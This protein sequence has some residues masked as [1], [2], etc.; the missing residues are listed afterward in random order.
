MPLVLSQPPAKNSLLGTQPGALVLRVRGPQQGGRLLRLRSTKCTIGASPDCTLRLRSRG[1]RPVHCL[2]LRGTAGTFVRRWSAGTYLN[3]AAFTESPLQPGDRLHIGPVE[4]EV[5]QTGAETEPCDPDLGSVATACPSPELSE[6]VHASVKQLQITLAETQSRLEQTNGA[7]QNDLEEA[8]TWKQAAAQREQE[9]TAA[10]AQFAQAEADWDAERSVL[11]EQIESLT[12]PNREI[13]AERTKLAEQAAQSAASLEAE[14]ARLLSQL[15]TANQT[16]QEK[17][18]RI[19]EL[20]ARVQ[21]QLSELALD[22]PSIPSP[23]PRTPQF[24]GG[25]EPAGDGASA[26]AVTPRGTLVLGMD[27]QPQQ[28]PAASVEDAQDVQAELTQATPPEETPTP[29]WGENDGEIQSYMRRLMER[30]GGGPRSESTVAEPRTAAPVAPRPAATPTAPMALTDVMEQPTEHP[31]EPV[32]VAP[33]KPPESTDDLSVLR[34]L[35]NDSAR[36][37]ISRAARHRY[38]TAALREL[39]SA[40]G[41]LVVGG[42]AFGLSPQLFSSLWFVG[43]IGIGTGAFMTLRGLRSTRQLRRLRIVAEPSE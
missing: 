2:I 3:D 12:D 21:S 19:A 36:G 9:L 11:R 15:E 26:P 13:E 34:E 24:G 41:M 7:H 5:L 23:A 17:T 35:A 22:T 16:I 27:F 39:I 18:R 33:R 4:L 32:T 29:T 8:A 10:K 20:E 30:V 31:P 37:F 40:A 14:S 42:T 43:V 28:P 38:Q 6:Q 25:I 1:V